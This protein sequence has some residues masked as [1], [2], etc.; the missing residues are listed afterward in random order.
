MSIQIFTP[1]VT[2]QIW[3]EPRLIYEPSYIRH[4]FHARLTFLALALLLAGCGKY[5]R[6]ALL[7][8]GDGVQFSVW[9]ETEWEHH[10]SYVLQ[11]QLGKD[12]VVPM[13]FVGV[14]PDQKMSFQLH[15]D[16]AGLVAIVENSRPDTVIGMYDK[17]TRE[18]WPHSGATESYLSVQKRGLRM[19]ERL[20]A[21]HPGSGFQ[22]SEG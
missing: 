19:V 3:K 4:V 1:F 2:T 5:S 14:V 15:N 16:G 10:R 20:R 6:V 13:T 8:A 7:D 9:K 12:V 22:L 21:A 18:S 11:V 17:I